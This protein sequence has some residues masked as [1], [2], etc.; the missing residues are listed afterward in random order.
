MQTVSL[1]QKDVLKSLFPFSLLNDE[2]LNRVSQFFELMHFPVGITIFSDGYPASDTYFI[3]TGKVKIQFHQKK[4]DRTLGVLGTGDHFGE[5]A[6]TGNQTYQTR[7]ICL[8]AVTV[9]RIRGSKARAIADAY[10]DLH[11]AFS[12][13]KRTQKLTS[14]ESLPWRGD[15]EG[16]V[17]FSRRHPIFLFLRLFLIGGAF[18]VVFSFLLFAALAS[19]NS[20][21]PLLILSLVEF[22][23]G[24]VICAWA[25]MEWRNDFFIL[26]RERVCVQKKLIGFYESR[27]E[28]PVNAILSVG[29]DTSF[30]GRMI[31]YGTVTVRTYTGDLQFKRLPYPYVIYELLEVRRQ[32]AVLEATQAEKQ[33]IREAL[34]GNEEGTSHLKTIRSTSNSNNY[35]EQTAQS[36]SF[37]NF[38][39]GLFNLRSENEDSVTY[40]THWWI[41]LKKTLAPGFLL[42]GIVLVVIIRLLGFMSIIPEMVIYSGALILAI[43]G[44]GWWIYQFQDWQNDVYIITDEQ[45]IDVYKKPLGNDDHRSAPVKNIQT[46]EFERK[47]LINLILNFGTVKIKIG[48]EEFTFDNVYQPS[49]VQAE[50]YA[51]YR[52]TLENAKKNEQHKFV[53]W[54]KTYEE[55]QKESKQAEGDERG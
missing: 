19:V 7:A 20:F 35:S 26:T 31:G 51:R 4:S 54:I 47:G 11:A 36:G 6:L 10:P 34:T 15:N 29:V 5:E 55:I 16:V 48:N 23:M 38:L 42:L 13:F 22:L 21:V 49:E 27:H 39:A 24:V 45:L 14:S 8:S 2:E 17:L 33:E 52:A 44:W 28:S 9:L 25:G 37:S 12:L 50:I 46:V 3:L 32:T 40:R 30:I 41:L 53:E 43:I 18:L 1:E